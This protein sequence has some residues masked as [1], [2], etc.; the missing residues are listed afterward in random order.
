MY[1]QLLIQVKLVVRLSRSGYFKAEP[2]GWTDCAPQNERWR[3]CSQTPP[4]QRRA[5]RMGEVW[6]RWPTP[7]MMR[8]GMNV[9]FN[10]AARHNAVY[11]AMLAVRPPK[12]QPT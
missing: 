12:H 3:Y 11:R 7:E 9:P 5:C 10:K 2:F 1:Y 8:L 4:R 6:F